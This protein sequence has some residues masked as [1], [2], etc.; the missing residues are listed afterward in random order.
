MNTPIL[1]TRKSILAKFD[2]MVTDLISVAE[3]E[4][5]KMVNAQNKAFELAEKIAK[6]DELADVAKEEAAAC[7]RAAEKIQALFN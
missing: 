2:K 3:A 4:D 5:K 1:K 6:Q 7:R